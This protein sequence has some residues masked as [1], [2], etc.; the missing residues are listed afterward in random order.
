MKKINVT[1]SYDGMIDGVSTYHRQQQTKSSWSSTSTKK[2]RSM[3]SFSSSNSQLVPVA[4]TTTTNKKKKKKSKNAESVAEAIWELMNS[5]HPLDTLS[6]PGAYGDNGSISRYHNPDHYTRALGSVLKS[7]GEG[8]WIVVRRAAENVGM[9]YY[10]PRI[11][12]KSLE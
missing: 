1:G 7:R 6:E 10:V 11:K 3:P 2:S 4:L 12:K 9:R 5:P 8:G